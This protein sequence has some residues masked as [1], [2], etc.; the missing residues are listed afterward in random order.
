M[1][2]APNSSTV[3]M[4]QYHPDW[5]DLNEDI[6]KG[7]H[8]EDWKAVQRIRDMH[9]GDVVYVMRAGGRGGGKAAKVEAVARI[10][11]DPYPSVGF[12]GVPYNAVNILYEA[13][14]EP[15]ITREEMQIDPILGQNH[16]L[17]IGRTGTNFILSHEEAGRLRQLTEH[18]TRSLSD[19]PLAH[20]GEAEPFKTD[21]GRAY[22]PASEDMVYTERVQVETSPEKI[23]RANRIHAGLQNSLA[24]HLEQL[25]LTPRSPGA[26]EPMFDIAWER[27]GT[28]YV[29]EVKSVTPENEQTQLRLGIAQVLMYRHLLT[30]RYGDA[31]AVLMVEHEP[32]SPLWNELCEHLGIL[33]VWPETLTSIR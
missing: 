4:F 9:I 16:A 28:V 1:S 22:Q 8:I 24:T 11:S 2:L 32:S 26:G 20:L 25:K 7:T 18:R 13:R 6:S 21:V 17:A 33:M 30:K 15:P 29:A 10:V 14:I 3:W 5:Y 19:E 23:G 31:R 12:D 27:D